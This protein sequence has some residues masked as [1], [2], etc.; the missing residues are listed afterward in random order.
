[1]WTPRLSPGHMMTLIVKLVQTESAMLSAET[2][3]TNKFKALLEEGGSVKF[4]RWDTFDANDFKKVSAYYNITMTEARDV[5]S[6]LCSKTRQR[7]I[8]EA[9]C[10]EGSREINFE[11][12]DL[13]LLHDL[14]FNIVTSESLL[15]PKQLQK[16]T[17]LYQCVLKKDV[18]NVLRNER[19]RLLE[20]WLQVLAA[21]PFR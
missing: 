9:Q 3:L 13:L 19:P 11:L 8:Q 20:V 14:S 15:K 16:L 7:I 1:M 2:T 21:Y 18:E 17:A 10:R 12:T 4:S 5:W 6:A